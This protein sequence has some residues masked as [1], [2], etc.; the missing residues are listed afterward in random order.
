MVA[1]VI[2]DYYEV[3][4]TTTRLSRTTMPSNREEMAEFKQAIKEFFTTTQPLM[5]SLENRIGACKVCCESVLKKMDDLDH[6]VIAME[7][8]LEFQ[9]QILQDHLEQQEM[10][11]CK[12]EQLG[13]E[14]EAVSRVSAR[15]EAVGIVPSEPS[16]PRIRP[17]ELSH[18][19]RMRIV[20]QLRRGGW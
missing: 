6:R 19:E 8:K 3:I 13:S 11:R 9:E 5:Q 10:M 17:R 16:D 2:V 15:H 20:D 18:E 1:T 7:E 14:L 4:P 12:L